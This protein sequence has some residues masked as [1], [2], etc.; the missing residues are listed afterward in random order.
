MSADYLS[1]SSGSSSSSSSS[2]SSNLGA[3]IVATARTKVGCPYEW[4]ATGPNSFDCSGLVYWS[5]AQHGIY[6]PRVSTDQA[7]SGKAVAFENMQPGD[8]MCF[9]NPVSHVGLYIG[10]NRYIHSPQPGEYVREQDIS[11]G[12]SNAFNRARRYW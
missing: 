4:G 6:L 8:V 5:H 7:N 11:Q 3:K 1:V 10:N 12:T 9:Y 2:S